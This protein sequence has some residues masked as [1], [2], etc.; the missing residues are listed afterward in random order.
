M[1]G[2]F[3]QAVIATLIEATLHIPER[4]S[5]RHEYWPATR[6]TP[7]GRYASTPWPCPERPELD[8]LWRD[9][10]SELQTHGLRFG[11]QTYGECGD[12]EIS[13]A[14]AVWC[15][16]LHRCPSVVIEPGVARGVTSRIVLEALNRNDLAHLW[17]ID[18]PHP[19]E[20]NLHAQL[21]RRLVHTEDV[22]RPLRGRAEG[23]YLPFFARYRSI[24]SFM[25]AC[26][27]PVT[28]D[29]RW[30]KR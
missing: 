14:R 25:T 20:R 12:A 16:V 8:V 9:I 27:P 18:L 15:T 19:F 3:L 21:E 10:A 30:S 28:C 29:S 17:S 2:R 11:R 1:F 5:M 4:I 26:I 24:S 22:A 7:I 23:G 13:L 6:L